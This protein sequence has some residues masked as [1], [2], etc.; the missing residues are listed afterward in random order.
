MFDK[1]DMPPLIHGATELILGNGS[2]LFPIGL[3]LT[4]FVMKSFFYREISL[5]YFYK[6]II[7]L[8]IEIKTVACSFVFA[9]AI[10]NPGD[11]IGLVFIALACLAVLCSSIGIYNYLKVDDMEVFGNKKTNI[12]L[13]FAFATSIFMMDFSIAIM[14]SVEPGTV[15]VAMGEIE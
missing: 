12:Y 10:L 6:S 13:L 4:T 9:S 5:L 15:A 11:A 7:V 2:W 14:Q 1:A 3:L 8:P